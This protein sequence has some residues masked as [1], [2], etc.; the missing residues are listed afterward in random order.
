MSILALRPRT[1]RKAECCRR[2]RG[3]SGEVLATSRAA[4]SLG[5][6]VLLSPQG[7]STLLCLV[8]FEYA[9]EVCAPSCLRRLY[10]LRILGVPLE[11]LMCALDGKELLIACTNL[12]WVRRERLTL[13]RPLDLGERRGS[14]DTERLQGTPNFLLGQCPVAAP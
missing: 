3:K 10:A 12:I 11:R 8:L 1:L 14:F 7:F 4:I 5:R 9:V 2:P 6:L 13:P